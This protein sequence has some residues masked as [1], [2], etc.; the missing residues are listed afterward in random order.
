MIEKIHQFGIRTIKKF[1]Y[2]KPILEKVWKKLPWEYRKSVYVKFAGW[3]MTTQHE[4]AWNDKFCCSVFRQTC[5]DLEKFNFTSSTNFTKESIY[6][7][8]WRHYFISFSTLYAIKCA[9]DH[10]YN[11]VECGVGDGVTAFFTLNELANNIDSNFKMHLYDAWSVMKKDSLLDSE[12]QNT[13]KYFDLSISRTKSNLKE[14]EKNIIYHEGT[15]PTTFNQ[16]PKSPES[17]VY[18]HIDINSSKPTLDILNFFFPK[19]VHGGVI[20][21]DDYGWNPYFDTKNVVDE[22]FSN[23][24]GILQ[25]LPTGQAIYFHSLDS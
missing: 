13:G 2:V 17:I 4:N 16:L 15:I 3:G 14:F 21:F 10:N 12:L 20:I 19:L 8:S 9:Q 22:F 5:I 23:K 1:P 11:F 25:K 24:N 6:E 7:H 18:L